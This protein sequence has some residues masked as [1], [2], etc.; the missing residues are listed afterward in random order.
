M[1]YDY[2]YGAEASLDDI[3]R[4]Q[5]RTREEYVDQGF[6]RRSVVAVAVAL[7]IVVAARDL[8]DPW[9]GVVGLLAAGALVAM[10][11]TNVRRATVRR[12][13]GRRE[14]LLLL[15]AAAALLAAIVGIRAATHALGLPAPHTVA[16]VM[17][18]LMSIVAAQR[19]RR[20]YAAVVRQEDLAADG[21]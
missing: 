3:R 8:P 21:R 18:A 6:A 16:G 15:G 20:A 11:V 13:P 9:D 7:L 19:V 10:A 17:V 12:H 5:D 2:D 1:T 14:L 4:M